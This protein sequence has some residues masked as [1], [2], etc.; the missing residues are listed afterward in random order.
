MSRTAEIKLTV[1]L[2]Q[3]NVPVAI[4][5]EASEAKSDGPTPCQ[6]MMLSLWD[7]DRRTM[8]AIDL[9]SRDTTVDD[10][11]LFFYQAFHQM[12]ETYQRATRNSELAKLIHEFGERFGGSVGLVGNGAANGRQRKL[13]DLVA[14]AEQRSD[15]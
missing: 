8:A 10:M 7:A 3:E 11:N 6:S 13:V 2:D 5:W 9:W 1:D 15:G 4:A 12:A 14:M